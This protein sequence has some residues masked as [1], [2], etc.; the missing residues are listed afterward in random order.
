MPLRRFAWLLPFVATVACGH[1]AAPAPTAVA[2]ALQNAPVTTAEWTPSVTLDGTLDP[3]ASVQL[4]FDVPGRIESLLAARG[5]VVAKGEAI[6]RLDDTMAAAQLA[7]AEAALGGAE[8]QLAAGESAWSRAQQL[9]AAG[10]MSPQQFKD[11]EAGVLAGRAGVA[12]AK[13]AVQLGKTYLANHTLRAPIAGTLTA[14]PDNAGMMVGGGT[15]L[16]FLEDLSALQLKGSVSEGDATWL[17][18]GLAVEVSS[19]APGSTATAKGVVTRVLPAL[20][21]VTRRLPGEVRIE[22]ETAGLFAHGYAHA[23]IHAE[24]PIVVSS[25]PHAAVVARPDFSVIVDRGNGKFERVS[26][27]VLQSGPEAD[28]VRGALVPGD[29]VVLYP[30]SGLGGEG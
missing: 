9:N 15:P 27:E 16:F 13:A 30:P 17:A 1:D 14:G 20:D 25:V 3:V 8:A 19:G 22:G 2:A 4:G 12:Q 23:T 11:A 24:A 7:Q 6:A 21:P 26:V 18:A 5:Q 10:G 29:S 28:L